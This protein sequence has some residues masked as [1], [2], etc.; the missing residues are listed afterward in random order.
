MA[1]TVRSLAEHADPDAAL[2]AYHRVDAAAFGSAPDPSVLGAKRPLVEPDRWLLASLDDEPCGGVGSFPFELT[3]PGGSTVPVSGV[4]DV[5]VLPT[6]RR[7][8]VL[9]TL[10]QRQLDELAERG[11]VAA[12]LHASEAGIY[13]RFGFG[14]ATRWRHV[15]IDVRGAAFAPGWPDPGG[16]Y[17]MVPRDEA[18]APCAEAHERARLARAGGLSR[19]EAWWRVVLG[20]VP[21]YLGGG[22]DR[23]VVLHAD[24]RGEVD[25]YAIYSV[26][27]D[28]SGGRAG[29]T[30]H[31]SEVVA[32]DER[33]ELGLW[34]TLLDHDLVE[35]A[36]GPLPVDHTLWDVLVDPRRARV[37]WEQDLLWA[38]PL[39]V[40]AA[41][42]ARTYAADGSVVLDVLDR[43][44][45]DTAGRFEL[46]AEQ[47]KASCEPT[48]RPAELRLDVSD[49][50]A[51]W[52]GDASVRRLVRAGRVE[53]LAEGAAARADAMFATERAPWCWVR[54]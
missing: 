44:R 13:R 19:S 34:R 10:L 22:R 53:E 12:V 24:D 31:A 17:R 54:F 20:E 4:A 1:L 21:L 28:W 16:R 14:P 30:L 47:G 51:C 38:R 32:A 50:A 40:P 25:G 11:D 7:R 39:D 9:R 48:T 35:R 36:T 15:D 49:L 5:G 27:E 42:S 26:R 8:G 29:H 6:H 43:F 52:L 46:G 2:A 18:L 33:V 41:L 45:P 23:H 3:V 37:R